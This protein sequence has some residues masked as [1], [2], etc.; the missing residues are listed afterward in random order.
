MIFP[1]KSY[2]LEGVS[3]RS[4]IRTYPIINIQN[5]WKSFNYRSQWV[6]SFE[7]FFDALFLH[8]V[9]FIYQ[10]S[11]LQAAEFTRFFRVSVCKGRSWFKH[12]NLIHIANTVVLLLNFFFQDYFFSRWS[13]EYQI[14]TQNS[15]RQE[16][17]ILRFN[18]RL[19]RHN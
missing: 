12:R 18:S 8:A 7:L 4:L 13:A 17:N 5:R 3:L 9:V 2:L 14:L 10:M 16:S 1:I 11:S 15:R 6:D 19:N